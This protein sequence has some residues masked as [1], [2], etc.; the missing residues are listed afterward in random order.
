MPMAR[1]SKKR[2]YRYIVVDGIDYAWRLDTSA[3]RVEVVLADTH[4]Q[5]LLVDSGSGKIPGS[6]SH[7]D[8]PPQSQA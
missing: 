1:P 4:N 2:G 5:K 7:T 3:T 8:L 6:L